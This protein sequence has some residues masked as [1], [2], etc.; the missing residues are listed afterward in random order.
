MESG[1]TAT[2][3]PDSDSGAAPLETGAAE[4]ARPVEALA[5]PLGLVLVD[6]VGL[7]VSDGG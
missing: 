5:V 6:V 7:A 2:A 3:L 4:F 1:D